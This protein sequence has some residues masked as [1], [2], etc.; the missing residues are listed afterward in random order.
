MFYRKFNS[1]PY[2]L[3]CVDLEG[4]ISLCINKYFTAHKAYLLV[5][6]GYNSMYDKYQVHVR[7]FN[8]WI[9]ESCNSNHD[10]AGSLI[11]DIMRCKSWVILR[12]PQQIICY[13]SL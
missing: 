1:I 11:N 13:Y 10:A 6:L 9:L 8:L 2:E 7:V 3:E 5:T 4:V 12:F